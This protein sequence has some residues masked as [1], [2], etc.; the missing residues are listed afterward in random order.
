MSLLK[1]T[2]KSVR[3]A[4]SGIMAT[5][6]LQSYFKTLCENKIIPLFTKRVN[7]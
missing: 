5:H 1:Y 6:I 2:E 4:V 7:I 3:A